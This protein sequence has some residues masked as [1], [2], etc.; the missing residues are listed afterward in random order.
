MAQVVY[1][2][3]ALANLERLFNFLLEQD[4]AM[5]LAMADLITGAVDTLKT[6]PLIG[7][8]LQGDIRELIISYGKSGYVTL[9]RFIPARDQVR[10]LAIR[11]QLELDYP[12]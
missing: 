11:H 4:P 9:Y 8:C 6:H 3:N 12:V 5:A 10:I 1:S 7:R 2:E